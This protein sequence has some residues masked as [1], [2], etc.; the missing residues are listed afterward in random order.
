MRKTD[1]SIG[2]REN[3]NFSTQKNKVPPKNSPFCCQGAQELILQYLRFSSSKIVL[4]A[5]LIFALHYALPSVGRLWP[6]DD[7]DDGGDD[8]ENDDDENDDDD[9]KAALPLRSH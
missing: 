3:L 1:S 5:I 9:G 7:Y 6:S 4:H 8:D 2:I